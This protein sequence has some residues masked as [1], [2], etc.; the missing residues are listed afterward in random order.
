MK[1]FNSPAQSQFVFSIFNMK[2]LLKHTPS[3]SMKFE[4][5][6]LGNTPQL[7]SMFSLPYIL[8][9]SVTILFWSAYHV[10]K[11][12]YVGF[13]LLGA[14]LD[15]DISWIITQKLTLIGLKYMYTV[16]KNKAQQLY[17]YNVATLSMEIKIVKWT[18]FDFSKQ[19]RRCV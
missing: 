19:S 4:V 9:I 15:F 12:Y 7:K 11:I 16:L 14:V 13:L 17:M 8:H 3:T 2:I 1:T 10:R 18:S 6:T 5:A